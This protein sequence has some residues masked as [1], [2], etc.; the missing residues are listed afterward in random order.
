[1]KEVRKFL[2]PQDLL[3][4]TSAGTLALEGVIALTGKRWRCHYTTRVDGGEP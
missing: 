2:L 3:G 4:H 1:M